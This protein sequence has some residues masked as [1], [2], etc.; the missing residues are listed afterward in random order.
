[1][2]DAVPTLFFGYMLDNGFDCH[3]EE[4]LSSGGGGNGSGDGNGAGA[5]PAQG[6]RS[7]EIDL[8]D[9]PHGSGLFTPLVGLEV[10]LDG[11]VDLSAEQWGAG[12]CTVDSIISAQHGEPWR[13]SEWTLDPYTLAV[14]AVVSLDDLLTGGFSAQPTTKRGGGAGGKERAGDEAPRLLPT[15]PISKRETMRRARD[16]RARIKHLKVQARRDEM[17]RKGVKCCDVVGCSEPRTSNGRRICAVHR[18]AKELVLEGETMIHRWCMH[19]YA[20]HALSAFS[21]ASRTICAEKYEFRRQRRVDRMNANTPE[22]EEVVGEEMLAPAPS[23]H[24]V[25]AA[26]LSAEATSAYL[27]THVYDVLDLKLDMHPAVIAAADDT[28]LW[29]AAAAVRPNGCFQPTRAGTPAAAAMAPGCTQLTMSSMLL[30]DN[31]SGG[32]NSG[33][34]GD[35]A[36][37]GGGTRYS[38]ERVLRTVASVGTTSLLQGE[39]W[40]VTLASNGGADDDEGGVYCATAHG[41]RVLTEHKG[42]SWP[43]E[44]RPPLCVVANANISVDMSGAPQPVA[45]RW[46]GDG[47]N[48]KSFTTNDVTPPVVS[49]R[50]PPSSHTS[51]L[52]VQVLAHGRGMGSEFQHILVLPND[53]E[54]NIGFAREIEGLYNLTVW[55]PLLSGAMSVRETTRKH[56]LRCIVTTDLA[57]LLCAEESCAVYEN[58]TVIA[59]AVRIVSGLRQVFTHGAG[60]PLLQ[61]RLRH[62]EQDLLDADADAPERNGEDSEPDTDRMSCLGAEV[63][64]SDHC[65]LG[66]AALT[67]TTKGSVLLQSERVLYI[68]STA[69]LI[70]LLSQTMTVVKSKAW[71][72]PLFTVARIHV[73]GFIYA[74]L[75]T[76]GVR[77]LS[78]RRWVTRQYEG[79]GITPRWFVRVFTDLIVFTITAQNAFISTLFCTPEATRLPN[80]WVIPPMIQASITT[81]AGFLRAEDSCLS[82]AYYA[83]PA[84]AALSA[85]I[86][87]AVHYYTFG[88]ARFIDVAFSGMHTWILWMW[89]VPAA[90]TIF[91]VRSAY[92]DRSQPGRLPQTAGARR[93]LGTTSRTP[94]IETLCGFHPKSLET[95][96]QSEKLHN[97][98]AML[99]RLRVIFGVILLAYHHK[100]LNGCAQLPP[101]VIRDCTVSV[102]TLCVT[103]ACAHL[104]QS[105]SK[106]RIVSVFH[107]YD[108]L[109]TACF[110]HF[111]WIE[112]ALVFFTRDGAA[113]YCYA[114]QAWCCNLLLAV[115]YGVSPAHYWTTCVVSS[116]SSA[117]KLWIFYNRWPVSEFSRMSS[118]KREA[119]QLAACFAVWTVVTLLV[120]LGVE[121]RH[122]RRFIANGARKLHHG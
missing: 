79:M 116:A 120:V 16:E 76:F 114:I 95:K 27:R 23:Q 112:D 58:R 70:V 54:W 88:H 64:D 109:V 80:M 21:S 2:G 122:R 41:G 74:M 47:I 24:I 7:C 68:H 85:S 36:G 108:G 45:V 22:P 92:G 106:I 118:F 82:T 35:G 20:L 100:V 31:G 37:Y 69:A 15:Q 46:F 101:V 63:A 33:G 72:L 32:G 90:I 49:C 13:A 62:I 10:E 75:F 94:L 12:S 60:C 102:G 42:L 38:R 8:S 25:T 48:V 81:M 56:Q 61:R 26:T 28:F 1:M 40:G 6:P 73:L 50:V 53:D 110:F 99:P 52:S 4:S 55:P 29:H 57:W 9:A 89:V 111:V 44:A 93:G 66:H 34:G 107:P 113:L 67:T 98:N 104:F 19:C 119:M 17:V 43:T 65:P 71:G 87:H 105:A 86:Y 77:N 115:A 96:F 59:R 3:E 14:D 78:V 103:I 84:Q 18:G 30:D 83:V 121:Y 91:A 5:A 11:N 97:T 51:I 117:L 39:R